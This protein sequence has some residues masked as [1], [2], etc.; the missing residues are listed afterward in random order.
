VEDWEPEEEKPEPEPTFEMLPEPERELPKIV[1]TGAEVADPRDP[2]IYEAREHTRMV[3]EIADNSPAA[4]LFMAR[5]LWNGAGKVGG[6]GKRI[7]DYLNER[8][9]DGQPYV[10]PFAGGGN[11]LWRIR[12]NGAPKF[13]S[14][15]CGLLIAWL[16]AAQSG[17]WEVPAKHFD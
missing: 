6:C 13:A 1:L 4:N 5:L 16:R 7:A 11:V 3:R 10:E 12:D 2:M 8:L 17:A 9:E 14:D 15:I